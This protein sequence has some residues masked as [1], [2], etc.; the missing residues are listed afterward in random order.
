[1]TSI[2]IAFRTWWNAQTRL[3]DPA[4]RPNLVE[5]AFLA[6]FKAGQKSYPTNWQDEPPADGMFIYAVPKGVDHWGLG[7]AYRTV[8]N[9]FEPVHVQTE[10]PSYATKFARLPD[11]PKR[12]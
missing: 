12:T 4:R 7:L 6:G 1:M 3:G 10:P 9:G 2:V 5:E 8:S 11:P